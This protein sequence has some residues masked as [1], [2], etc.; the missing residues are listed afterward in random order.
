LRRELGVQVERSVQR[1]GKGLYGPADLLVFDR[2]GN[3][4]LLAVEVKRVEAL[5]IGKLVEVVRQARE[6]AE[7]APTVVMHR[8]NAEP[9]LVSMHICDFV[10]VARAVVK[11]LEA[12]DDAPR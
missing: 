1:S 6:E 4:S 9:W 10:R 8:K 12:D 5:S 2:A 3:L 7:G 11:L